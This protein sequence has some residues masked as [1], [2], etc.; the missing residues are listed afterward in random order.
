MRPASEYAVAVRSAAMLLRLFGGVLPNYEAE[1]RQQLVTEFTPELGAADAG[2]LAASI[3]E[4][5][6]QLNAGT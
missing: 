1:M 4:E 6:K 3:L 5:A 2:E